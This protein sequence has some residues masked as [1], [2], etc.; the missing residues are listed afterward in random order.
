[1][2]KKLKLKACRN[3]KALV[4]TGAE[5]CPVCGSTAF[6]KLWRGYVIVIDPAGSEVAKKM[7]VTVPGMYAI[8]LSR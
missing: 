5:K 2:P 7:N 8:R 4:D 1:M 3:C 6:T